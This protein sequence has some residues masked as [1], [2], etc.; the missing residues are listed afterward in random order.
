MCP[1]GSETETGSFR[2][3]ALILHQVPAASSCSAPQSL[4]N[5][6]SLIPDQ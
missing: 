2:D 3:A 1:E 6:S 4:N 5:E